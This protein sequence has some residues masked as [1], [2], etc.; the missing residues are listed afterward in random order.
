MITYD[1]RAK[2]EMVNALR[3]LKKICEEQTDGC[4]ECPF[5]RQDDSCLMQTVSPNN[6]RIIDDSK[7]WKAFY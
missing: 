1:E 4:E 2:R 7:V 5:S 3:I 6:Y